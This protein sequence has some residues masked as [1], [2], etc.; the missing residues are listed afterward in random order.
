[1]GDVLADGI[2]DH[3]TKGDEFRTTPLQG[4]RFRKLYLHDG[5]ATTLESAITAHGG[6]AEWAVRAYQGATGD[7]RAAL[8][9]FLDTLRMS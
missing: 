7:Q 5:R 4:L 3:D 6:E 9:R 8:L 2:P 1:M